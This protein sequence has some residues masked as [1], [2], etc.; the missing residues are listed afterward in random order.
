VVASAHDQAVR[1]GLM[2]IDGIDA[3]LRERTQP[4]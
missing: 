4:S 2:L 3:E 1:F